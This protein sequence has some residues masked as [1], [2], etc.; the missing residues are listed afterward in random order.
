MSTCT[1]SGCLGVPL[2]LCAVSS[3]SIALQYTGIFLP[4]TVFLILVVQGSWHFHLNNI[5]GV[6]EPLPHSWTSIPIKHIS[7]WSLAYE[8]EWK[9]SK[10]GCFLLYREPDIWQ[11]SGWGFFSERVVVS[12]FYRYR[13]F[14]LHETW[15]QRVLGI[16]KWVGFYQGNRWLKQVE[17]RK[18]AYFSHENLVVLHYDVPIFSWQW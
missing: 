15:G 7:L 1:L 18:S 3:H 4:W 12:T 6:W 9:Q 2:S 16:I 8:T 14:N 11:A 17:D 13:T 5:V 10:S